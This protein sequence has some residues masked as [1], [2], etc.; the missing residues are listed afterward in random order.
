MVTIDKIQAQS[1]TDFGTNG[2]RRLRSQGIV[3]ANIYGHKQD[4]LPIQINSDLIRTMIGSGS[5]VFD[6]ECGETT[7]KVLVKEVQWDTFSKHVMHVDFQRVDPNER[8][9]VDVPIHLRGTAPGSLVGGVVAHLMHS[10]EVECLAVQ[11]PDFIDVKIGHLEIGGAVHVSDLTDLPAGLVVTVPAD[12]IIV[13]VTH[14]APEVEPVDMATAP[15]EPE[16]IGAK[17]EEPED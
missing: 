1:R 17:P 9:T 16:R 6:L 5:H 14:E 3:P 11:I 15:L 2:S 12:S 7:E 4:P 13:Q 10:I 8:V